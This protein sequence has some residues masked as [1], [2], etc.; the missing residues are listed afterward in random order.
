MNE[1]DRILEGLLKLDED[2]QDYPID[3]RLRNLLTEMRRQL[4]KP[5]A[6]PII[7]K[8]SSLMEKKISEAF[9]NGYMLGHN[10]TVESCYGDPEEKA[11]DYLNETRLEEK[12]P[13][14]EP[15]K[16]K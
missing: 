2:G 7:L 4:N 8:E 9:E 11:E 15:P 10:D 13:L 6:L 3:T 5:K 1:A 14:P 16:G 12:Q